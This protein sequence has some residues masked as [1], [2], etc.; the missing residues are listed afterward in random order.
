MI[1]YYRKRRTAAILYA[2]MIFSVIVTVFGC[3]Q[4]VY[5]KLAFCPKT[6]AAVVFVDVKESDC[7][8]IKLPD[9]KNVLI[10]CGEYDKT[11]LSAIKAVLAYYGVQEID[12][13]ILST[14]LSE[15][16]GNVPAL[17][18]EYNV[19]TAYIP[20]VYDKDLFPSFCAA[21]NALESCG[22]KVKTTSNDLSVSSAADDY[23]IAFL[24][25]EN[26]YVTDGAY[27]QMTL[28]EN[29]SAKQIN[30]ISAIVYFE[31]A[32]VRFVFDGNAETESETKVCQ[33]FKSGYYDA[34]FPSAAHRIDLYGIDVLKAGNHGGAQSNC[35]D[36]L[37]M[38]APSN[39]VISVGTNNKGN[40]ATKTL[41]G[42]RTSNEYCNIY[43]TDYFG[44]VA[45]GVSS[46]G[47]YK[48][49]HGGKI[50]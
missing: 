1:K 43:R 45:V 3:K 16:T 22:A 9:G 44:T 34:A 25:P 29:P 4:T 47:N 5:D 46:D 40:P 49:Y 38:L 33:A 13:L 35:E 30:N 7:T 32:G 48:F 18:E 23:V 21:K 14:P 8:F 31:Y 12:Y 17:V 15:H 11:N 28:S 24:S 2:A 50:R 6:D 27:A 41:A 37:S 10:D 42:L 20:Y 26:F 19:K 36:F 39:A